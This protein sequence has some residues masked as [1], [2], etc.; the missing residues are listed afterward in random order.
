MIWVPP[1]NGLVCNTIEP[2]M[3]P[4][5]LRNASFYYSGML[6]SHPDP[7]TEGLGLKGLQ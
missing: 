7:R 6:T 4:D 1:M 3:S 5:N 2:G